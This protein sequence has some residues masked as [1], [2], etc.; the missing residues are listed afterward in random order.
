ME[1]IWK[2]YKTQRLSQHGMYYQVADIEI[3]NFGNVR[4]RLWRC[5][6]YTNDKITLVK[7][8]RCIGNSLTNGIYKLVY[9]LFVGP[10]PKGYAVHHI[11]FNKLND[12]LDNLMLMTKSE[13]M[14][15]HSSE[16]WKDES[17]IEKMKL[18]L[19]PKGALGMFWFNNGIKETLAHECPEGFVSG[20]L[21]NKN[22]QCKQL[23]NQ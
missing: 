1:E 7:G 5:K 21:K 14:K 22:K 10:I 16:R 11:D 3:S 4:G 17:C 20:R 15:L 12:R 19:N 8:R 18:H 2:E 6:P 13:H 23:Q 9:Q